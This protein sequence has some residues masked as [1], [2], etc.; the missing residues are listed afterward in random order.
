VSP[1]NIR[2]EGE[3]HPEDHCDDQDV[4]M[5]EKRNVRKEEKQRTEWRNKRSKKML[6]D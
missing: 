3:G 4:K 1:D 5:P 2:Q 6:I